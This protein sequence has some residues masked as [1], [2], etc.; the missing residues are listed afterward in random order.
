MWTLLIRLPFWQKYIIRLEELLVLIPR[1]SRSWK[2]IRL[3]K[4]MCFFSLSMSQITFLSHDP[5]GSRGKTFKTAG[6]PVQLT[7]VSFEYWKFSLGFKVEI[8]D[9]QERSSVILVLRNSRLNNWQKESQ[10]QGH[11]TTVLCKI[12]VRRSKYCLKVY[13]TWRRLKISR[14]RFQSDRIFDAY[15]INSP[16]FSEV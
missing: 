2:R 9:R 14:W 4:I 3:M 10:A 15:L 8:I 16:R 1:E 6:V 13:I 5:F 11:P 12:S 7:S